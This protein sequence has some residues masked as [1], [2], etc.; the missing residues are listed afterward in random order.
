[1]SANGSFLQSTCPL[2]T[3]D[4]YAAAFRKYMHTQQYANM[5]LFAAGAFEVKVTV[6]NLACR[7]VR[8]VIYR[9]NTDPDVN[10]GF[11]D[12]FLSI[13]GEGTP[14]LDLASNSLTCGV[15][16]SDDCPTIGGVPLPIIDSGPFD[17]GAVLQIN[18]G[19]IGRGERKIFRFY[20]GLFDNPEAAERCAAG[21]RMSL[22]AT[23]TDRSSRTFLLGFRRSVTTGRSG[24]RRCTDWDGA[25]APMPEA[26]AAPMTAA[27]AAAFK[28]DVE[29]KGR[30]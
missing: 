4:A 24:L 7:P 22:R 18:L 20:Y 6:D 19:E 10:V 26:D 14:F 8:D 3:S 21:A 23:A 2:L 29:E 11:T 1:M 25:A 5:D 27:A 30:R 28:A 9:R 17:Q 12:D 13:V 15:L 16:P